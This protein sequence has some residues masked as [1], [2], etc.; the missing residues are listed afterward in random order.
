[1]NRRSLFKF[2]PALV[3]VAALPALEAKPI[4]KTGPILLERTCDRGWNSLTPE[5]QK[6][7]TL[8]AQRQGFDV[9]IYQGCG[10]TFQWYFGGGGYPTCP[11]CGYC[12]MVT[13]EDLKSGRYAPR[14]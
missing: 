11:N 13:L 1:M 9:R 6:E 2:L 3:S 14:G 10:T 4:K 5:Q 8:Y 7:Q 12:Y